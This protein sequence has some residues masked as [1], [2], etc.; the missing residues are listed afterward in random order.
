MSPEE[1]SVK[2]KTFAH[3]EFSSP[4]FSDVNII[5][6]KIRD[7]VDLFNRGHK[8]L[9]VD[10]DNTFPEYIIVNKDYYQKWLV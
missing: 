10:I 1:I 2:L 9:K 8:Y 5:R 4:N 6:N 3:S 7:K